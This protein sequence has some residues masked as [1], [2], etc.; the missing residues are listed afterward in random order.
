M[1]VTERRHIQ[2]EQHEQFARGF[3]AYLMEGSRG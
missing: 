3:E 1:G 2:R